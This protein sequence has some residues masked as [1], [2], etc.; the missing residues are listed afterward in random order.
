MQ[1]ELIFKGNDMRLA[2]FCQGEF[3]E[4]GNGL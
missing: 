2:S 4:L 1:I 3:W